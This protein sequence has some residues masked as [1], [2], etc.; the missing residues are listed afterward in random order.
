MEQELRE[1]ED[2][3]HKYINDYK[4]IRDD[5]VGDAYKY[6]DGMIQGFRIAVLEVAYILKS[7]QPS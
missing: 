6:Y 3:L 7:N 4:I 5:S 2:R 1:L